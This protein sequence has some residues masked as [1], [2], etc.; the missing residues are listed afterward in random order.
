MKKYFWNIFLGLHGVLL[1]HDCVWLR[2]GDRLFV[3]LLTGL[4]KEGEADK[5]GKHPASATGKPA[6]MLWYAIL[7][8]RFIKR[9]SLTL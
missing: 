9:S 6:T 8:A 3:W 7:Y 5:G 1:E 2:C 4:Y